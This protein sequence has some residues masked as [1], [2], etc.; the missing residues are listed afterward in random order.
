MLRLSRHGCSLVLAVLS[1][2]AAG[3]SS[4]CRLLCAEW[5]DYQRD[6]CGVVDTE[7]L[8]VTC[9]ADY[10]TPLG[11]SGEL[12]ECQVR[13]RELAALRR[14]RDDTL[15]EAC[16]TWDADACGILDRGPDD[17]DSASP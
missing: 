7:D 1:A 11:T 15:Q 17:D 8:R 16:C 2:V 6:V 9:V 10:A 14:F 5:Y 12:R 13:R 4:E 3:C